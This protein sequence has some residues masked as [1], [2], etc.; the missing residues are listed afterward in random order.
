M[1]G[2]LAPS[3]AAG[4]PFPRGFY[5]ARSVRASSRD[6]AALQVLGLVHA[7]ARAAAIAR[8]WNSPPPD[9]TVYEI[10]E[11][12]PDDPFDEEPQGFIFYD[13]SGDI[14]PVEE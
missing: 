3:L 9:L 5:T 14:S 7:D 10:V 8:E 1:H 2:V 6:E 4:G 11:L 12:N 13:E